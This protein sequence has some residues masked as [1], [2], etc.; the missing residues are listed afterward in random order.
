MEK[1]DMRSYFVPSP[2][3]RLSDIILP[4]TLKEK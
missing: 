2:L 1:L 3:N 4:K